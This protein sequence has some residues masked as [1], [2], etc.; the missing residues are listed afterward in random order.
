MGITA[1]RRG[2]LHLLAECSANWTS[3]SAGWGTIPRRPLSPGLWHGMNCSARKT[4]VWSTAASGRACACE[5]PPGDVP[6]IG[7]NKRQSQFGRL[8]TQCADCG[9]L[10]EAVL[11]SSVS[12]M[13]ESSSRNV[14]WTLFLVENTCCFPPKTLLLSYPYTCGLWDKTSSKASPHTTASRFLSH[15]YSAVVTDFPA[16]ITLPF[17]PVPAG[18]RSSRPCSDI[19]NLYPVIFPSCGYCLISLTACFYFFAAVSS[20]CTNPPIPQPVSAGEQDERVRFC[21]SLWRSVSP[22]EIETCFT[23][24]R[25]TILPTTQQRRE[26]TTCHC[27]AT[28]IPTAFFIN[29]IIKCQ[30]NGSI[31]PAWNVRTLVFSF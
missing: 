31:G 2:R 29:I 22:E 11:T 16:A 19:F 8:R 13:H 18:Y 23:D 6:A 1:V 4:H 7:G 28:S 30:D 10:N 25:V 3:D 5:T 15:S 26:Q 27:C 17:V 12:N 21:R 14:K 24:L 20:S 9:L